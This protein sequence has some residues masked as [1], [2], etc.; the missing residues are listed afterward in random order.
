[1]IDFYWPNRQ[2]VALAAIAFLVVLHPKFEKKATPEI[3]KKKKKTVAF[4][5]FAILCI[6]SCATPF[7]TS[8]LVGRV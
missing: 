1:M 7:F 5:T 4:S 6:S 8:S 3:L 2:G